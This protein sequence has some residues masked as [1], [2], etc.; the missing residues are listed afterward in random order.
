VSDPGDREI[1]RDETEAVLRIG[2]KLIVSE[3][4]LRE[5]EKRHAA[6][7][8]ALGVARHDHEAGGEP[9]SQ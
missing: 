6:A 2:R 3:A 1:V 4:D 9:M 7:L 5:L 8:A